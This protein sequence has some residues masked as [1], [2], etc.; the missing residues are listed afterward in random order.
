MARHK[1]VMTF[2]YFIKAAPYLLDLNRWELV[3]ILHK[4][5]E[6]IYLLVLQIHGGRGPAVAHAEVLEGCA[7]A[8]INP[9]VRVSATT[10]RP[11][12]KEGVS[13]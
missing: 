13:I 1:S 4:V 9:D 12:I 7:D 3:S 10:G 8:V 5:D 11:P 2:E 6:A